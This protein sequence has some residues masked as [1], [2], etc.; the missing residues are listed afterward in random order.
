[1][2][3]EITDQVSKVGTALTTPVK[4]DA[5]LRLEVFFFFFSQTDYF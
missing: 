1:M 2:L 3:Q 5:A 4:A